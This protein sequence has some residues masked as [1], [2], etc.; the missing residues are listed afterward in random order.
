MPEPEY[1]ITVSPDDQQVEVTLRAPNGDKWEYGIPYNTETGRFDFE[2][3]KVI[4][5]DF[6]SEF[7][8][9][10]LGDIRNAV[11]NSIEGR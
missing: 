6:G 5:I 10:M 1:K 9:K 2:D 11:R 7:A 4:E 8:E 3:I